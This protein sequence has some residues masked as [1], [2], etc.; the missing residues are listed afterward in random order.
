MNKYPLII[1]TGPTAT[2]KTKLAAELAVQINAEI[3]S[4]DSRQVYKEMNL[5]TGKDYDDYVVNG[6]SIKYHLIDIVEPGYEYSVYEFQRDFNNAYKEIQSRNKNVILCGGTGFYI[7][8][9]LGIKKYTK[10]DVNEDLR[11]QLNNSTTEELIIKLLKKL[12]NTTDITDRDRLI[13]AIEI[14]LC[15]HNETDYTPLIPL[16]SISFLIDLSRNEINNKI[17]TRLE[18]RLECGMVDEVEAL[19]K[20]GISYNKL[21]YYGLEYKFIA[22]YLLKEIT[23]SEMQE[24]LAIAIS[25]FAKRQNTWFKRM[26]RQGIKLQKINGNISN[27]KKIELILNELKNHAE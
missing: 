7:E 22:S 21:K 14:E 18:K 19:T 24:K 12:H 23:Y 4:A 1:I 13:R 9:A 2:G 16:K 17:K 20:K 10:I 15:K 6:Q 3:I 8:A 25:Q 11:K 27:T 26:E 5:G